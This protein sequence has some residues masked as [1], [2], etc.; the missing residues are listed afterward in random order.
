MSFFSMNPR[1]RY[2]FPGSYGTDDIMPSF[3]PLSAMPLT[4]GNWGG[5]GGHD[6]TTSPIP[7]HPGGSLGVPRVNISESPSSYTLSLS[8]PGIDPS[9]ISI[10][11]EGSING[12]TPRLL[13]VSVS[14]S[15][16][17]QYPPLQSPQSQGVNGSAAPSAP[18]AA[19]AVAAKK[20]GKN[21]N[22][23]GG[24]TPGP[25][26]PAPEVT[27][28]STTSTPQ[29]RE[30]YH[31]IER[32]EGFSSRTFVVPP[33]CDVDKIGANLEHG[34]LYI[35]LPK[36]AAN[37]LPPSRDIRKIPVQLGCRSGPTAGS[38]A[39][40]PP[41]QSLGSGRPNASPDLGVVNTPAKTSQ[42]GPA[43]AVHVPISST[44]K[45]PPP[46]AA[47]MSGP[48]GSAAA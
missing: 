48:E 1:P 19:A 34:V 9:N 22:S 47:A 26:I 2:Q 5:I 17:H 27:V 36:M 40:A 20:G 13:K 18:A 30:V 23:K 29:D 15:S 12:P 21:A 41:D 6:N 28:P 32:H 7:R 24:V 25:Q 10:T 46:R 3:G 4:L 43:A 37:L 31:Y 42:P 16:S 45:V 35:G 44:T 8:I 39:M 14:S 33:D 38:I 11:Q